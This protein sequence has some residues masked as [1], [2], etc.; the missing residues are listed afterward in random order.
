[1]FFISVYSSSIL[2]NSKIFQNYE[3]PGTITN[4]MKMTL[5]NGFKKIICLIYSNW[6]FFLL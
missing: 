4:G 3:L 1:M 5:W 2:L 6:W